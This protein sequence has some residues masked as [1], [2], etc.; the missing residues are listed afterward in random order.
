[1]EEKDISLEIAK[2][3]KK[4]GFNLDWAK[5]LYVDDG[6]VTYTKRNDYPRDYNEDYNYN[7]YPKATIQMAEDWLKTK[8]HLYIHLS[9]SPSDDKTVWIPHILDIRDCSCVDDG[10]I[11]ICDT[12][13]EAHEKSIIY[14][15]K[16]LVTMNKKFDLGEIEFSLHKNGF[17]KGFVLKR[18]LETRECREIME[19]ILGIPV[20]CEDDFFDDSDEY[21]VY[22]KVL[23]NDV[24]G[25]L[26]GERDDSTI[27]D[28]AACMDDTLPLGVFNIF[29]VANYLKEKGII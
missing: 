15:F 6:E 14:C 16:E 2:L 18:D 8:Y 12:P 7:Y 10:S 9:P 24:N 28:Y 20:E 3:L 25:W 22:N 26:K 17:T 27:T 5:L 1:M 29:P 13:E 21:L 19:D 4:D 11:P 23:T